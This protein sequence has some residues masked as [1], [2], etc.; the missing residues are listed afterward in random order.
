MHVNI[1]AWLRKVPVSLRL[2][3]ACSGPGHGN[4]SCVWGSDAG[5]PGYTL[6]PRH[7][8]APHLHTPYWAQPFWPWKCGEILSKSFSTLKL[9]SE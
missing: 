5:D 2:P 7:R 9:T 1:S 4:P 6:A 3:R 8:A